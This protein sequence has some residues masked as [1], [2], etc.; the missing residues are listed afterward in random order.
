MFYEKLTPENLKNSREVEDYYTRDIRNKNIKVIE[1]E[2]E[3]LETNADYHRTLYVMK[4]ELVNTQTNNAIHTFYSKSHRKDGKYYKCPFKIFNIGQEQ[5]FVNYY[6]T[7]I[8]FINLD[9]L[10]IYTYEHFTTDDL[11]YDSMIIDEI[12][13]FVSNDKTITLFVDL[14]FPYTTGYSGQLG[15]FDFTDPKSGLKMLD[16]E[17]LYDNID[18]YDFIETP[19]HSDYKIKYEMVDDKIIINGYG[20]YINIDT[21]GVIITHEYWDFREKTYGDNKYYWHCATC[22]DEHTCVERI[23]E[24]FTFRV[25]ISRIGM[26]LIVDGIEK[27]P[28]PKAKS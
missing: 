10:E 14:E 6:S 13:S 12:H 7:N 26:K 5:W 28:K 23:Y 20:S 16:V 21:N 4:Y 11:R 8:G 17:N 3:I 1:S 9:K 19:D 24:K 22:S 2:Y 18:D 25:S 27:I 15:F